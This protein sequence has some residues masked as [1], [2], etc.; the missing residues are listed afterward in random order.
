MLFWSSV[1]LSIKLILLQMSILD[2]IL[3]GF[4]NI[5]QHKRQSI[6]AMSTHVVNRKVNPI[7][8]PVKKSAR[9]VKGINEQLQ[10]IRLTSENI[11]IHITPVSAEEE[12]QKRVRG[13]EYFTL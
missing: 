2:T 1:T 13:Y 8:R 5:N 7:I 3:K 6:T 12:R 10:D 4:T 11:T 9:I